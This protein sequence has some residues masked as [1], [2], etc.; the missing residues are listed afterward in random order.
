MP[1]VEF[2]ILNETGDNSRLR[3]ACQLIE[4]ACAQGQRCYVCTTS[5]DQARR[6]D[7]VLWTFRDQ[8]FIPH[9]IHSDSSP[10]HPRIMALIGSHAQ[11]PPEFQSLLINLCD[12]VP[13][14]PDRFARICEVV[15]ADPQH[16]QLARE[17]YRQYREQGCQLETKNV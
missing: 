7:D 12:A 14:N 15:D 6:M 10:S 17:R 9:E 3:Y 5:D 11:V 2:H 8:A 1:P 4:R 16:K 13:D